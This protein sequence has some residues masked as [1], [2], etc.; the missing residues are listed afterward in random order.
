MVFTTLSALIE[1]QR[2][3]NF[4]SI[5]NIY[6]KQRP[7]LNSYVFEK[8]SLGWSPEQIAGRLKK[9]IKEGKRI[10]S[11]YINHESIYQYIYHYE[12]KE[13]SRRRCV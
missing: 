7:T 3:K 9:E 10:P 2:Q 13:Y 6:S 1:H 8:L 11:E 4:N 12:Q 5:K